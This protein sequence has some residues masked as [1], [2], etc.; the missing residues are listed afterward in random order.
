MDDMSSH[1]TGG[2]EVK[3]FKRICIK[4]YIV[5][6]GDKMLE[7]KRGEEYITSE[8]R[9]GNVIVFSRFWGSVPATIFSGA[10]RFT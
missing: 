8:K 3:T 2:G 6:D 1:C 9:R 7:L 4:N 5:E 10:V